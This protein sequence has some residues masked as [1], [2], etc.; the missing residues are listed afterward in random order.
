M[1]TEK[2]NLLET[3][4]SLYIN[5]MNVLKAGENGQSPYV[6]FRRSKRACSG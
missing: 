1:N 3:Y 5:P 6:I 4:L 2:I